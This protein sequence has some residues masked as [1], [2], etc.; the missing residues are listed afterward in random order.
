M[1]QYGMVVDISKCN[2]CYNC[3]LACRDEYAGNDYPPYSAAQPLHG[4]YWMQIGERER[5]TYPKVKVSYIPLPCLH[6]REASCIT[7]SPGDAVHRRPD[8]IVL[9]DPEKAV[10]KKEI[11]NKCPH[12]VIYWN[13]E[14]N[15]PQKCTFCA[16]LLDEGWKEPRCVEAC[17]TGALIFGDLDDP[18]S[19]IVGMLKSDKTEELHPEYGLAPGV[20]YVGL[21]KRFIAGEVVLGDQQD[22]CAE[23][24]KVTLIRG[25]E[26]RN[27]ITDNYGDF[28]FED[29]EPNSSYTIRIDHEGYILKEM[30]VL[31]RLDTNLGEIILEPQS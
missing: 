20:V 10:G 22:E 2:G 16:H 31:T 29:L 5:G 17:P 11:V 1:T 9:I 14:K 28:E 8:G 18:G 3:F 4:Q 19:E 6:C 7:A 30:T 13:E 24:V 15:I 25:N 12:R 27:L 21:P 23:G 26:S